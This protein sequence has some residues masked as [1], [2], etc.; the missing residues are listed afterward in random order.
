MN[1]IYALAR[2]AA[3]SQ[4]ACLITK[5][6]TSPLVMKTGRAVSPW[7]EPAT[8]GGRLPRAGD[9]VIIPPGGRVVLDVSPPPLKG[10]QVDGMLL[11]DDQDLN[12]SAGHI[13]VHGEFRIGSATQ[14]FLHHAVITLTSGGKADAIPGLGGKALA[15]ADG[16]LIELHGE[17]RDSRVKLGASAELGAD[18][19]IVDRVTNWRPGDRLVL[20]S[21]GPRPLNTETRTIAAAYQ[22]VIRLNE[23]LRH[24][25]WGG[26]HVFPGGTLDQRAEVRL[27]SRNIIVRGANTG[28][29][30]YGGCVAALP[31]GW[32]RLS[33]VEFTALGQPGRY[34]IHCHPAAD[35]AAVWMVGCSLHR[36]IQP[37]LLL[38][39]RDPQ[40]LEQNVVWDMG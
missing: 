9:T 17:W 5:P 35:P 21:A 6:G 12:L 24:S 1:A 30:L 7:S 16:G 22:N 26:L 15:A 32:L 39:R 28:E 14:P 40:L 2:P 31:G 29:A 25:Y 13:L 34:A 18:E 23:P 4:L 36:N 3:R 38:M 10:L 19:I 37:G 8:W 20:G 27:I 33:G 11:F